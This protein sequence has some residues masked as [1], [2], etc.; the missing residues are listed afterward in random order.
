M[1]EIDDNFWQGY[2]TRFKMAVEL[3]CDTCCAAVIAWS[4]TS[5]RQK[6]LLYQYINGNMLLQSDT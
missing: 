1:A 6:M 3:S 5:D 2:T 4:H